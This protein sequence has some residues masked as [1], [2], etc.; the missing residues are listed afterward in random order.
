MKLRSIGEWKIMG[1][2]CLYR[3]STFKEKALKLSVLGLTSQA[4]VLR[5]PTNVN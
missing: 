1:F 2:Y 3:L 5:S 4:D